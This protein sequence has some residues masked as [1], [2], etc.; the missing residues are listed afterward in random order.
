[1]RYV[2]GLIA[3]LACGV[4]IGVLST[5]EPGPQIIQVE[6]ERPL[7]GATLKAQADAEIEAYNRGMEAGKFIGCDISD[8][9]RKVHQP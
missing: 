2:I 8:T 9:E 4:F 7:S 3:A 6:V 5:P 1:M